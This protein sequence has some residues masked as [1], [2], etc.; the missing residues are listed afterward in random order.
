MSH[1]LSLG[2]VNDTHRSARDAF[3]SSRQQGRAKPVASSLQPD[4]ALGDHPLD[5]AVPIMEPKKLLP[6]TPP[7]PVKES[8]NVPRDAN[9]LERRLEFVVRQVQGANETTN[10]LRSAFH[11]LEASTARSVQQLIDAN[12]LST[13]LLTIRGE[14]VMNAPQFTDAEGKIGDPMVPVERGSSLVL[15]YPMVREQGSVLMRR[16]NV[17]PHTAAVTWTWVVLYSKGP[18]GGEKTF[19][20]DFSC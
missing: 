7:E 16:M 1:K 4:E 19:F 13:S 18:N 14:C 8:F 12:K 10:S 17:N 5:M 2:F 6:M 20:G 9:M 3:V 11:T 15:A